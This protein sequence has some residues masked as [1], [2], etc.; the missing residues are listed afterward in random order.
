MKLRNFL[1]MMAIAFCATG[2]VSCGDDDDDDDTEIV[3]PSSTIA[4]K[5]KGSYNGKITMAVGDSAL[6]EAD[7]TIIV[8]PANN[9]KFSI[10]LPE[11]KMA[12]GPMVKVVPSKT[13]ENVEIKEVADNK[14]AFE[15]GPFEQL[16]DETNYKSTGAKGMIEGNVMNLTFDVTPGAMPMAIMITFVGNK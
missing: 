4:E 3:N 2:M 8:T 12:M 13:I 10:T 15:V 16:V 7:A 6:P 1:A 5:V 9:G 14:Y 11:M